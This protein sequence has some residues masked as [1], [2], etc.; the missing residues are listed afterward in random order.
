MYKINLMRIKQFDAN[1]IYVGSISF[2]E[3]NK[4][5]RLTARSATEKEQYQRESDKS[6]IKSISEYVYRSQTSSIIP[7]P[8]PLVLGTNTE[9]Y[10]SFNEDEI[11]MYLSK[12]NAKAVL[13][14][15]NNDIDTESDFFQLYLPETEKSIFIVDG[16][17]RFLGTKSFFES[18]EY[19]KSFN[20]LEFIVTFLLDYSIYE[21]ASVF[22]DI[23]FKQKPVNRS[24]YYDIFG[25]YA[26]DKNEI[27]FSYFL[28][29]ALNESTE[30]KNTIKMLGKGSGVVSLASMVEI[31]IK[32]LISP[33]GNLFNL[34][35]GY[36]HNNSEDYINLPEIFIDY[37]LY[38]K[39]KYI[40]YFPNI[41]LAD[42]ALKKFFFTKDFSSNDSKASIIRECEN[43]KSFSSMPIEEF[44]NVS[45]I[46]QA[47][48]SDKQN[49]MNRLYS[50]GYSTPYYNS[51]N[52]KK[53]YLFKAIGMYALL[54]IF[55]DIYPGVN[56]SRYTKESFYILLDEKFR[57]VNAEP[58]FFFEDE[59]LQG[60]GS[61]ALQTLCYKI[62]RSAVIDDDYD[63]HQKS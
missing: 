11:E 10:E 8:T 27:S 57:L 25:S 4:R 63:K 16:Q 56:S 62:L 44:F 41:M 53:S 19:D 39:K 38:I 61:A 13:V 26:E 15:N 58:S 60:S 23:N 2:S 59:R 42:E 48:C 51:Y 28:V 12:D 18:E 35:N 50:H 1:D 47:V 55:N 21:Q 30:Y 32:E 40:E 17:H 5:V 54:K 45:P 20:D 46:L 3:L 36:V 37:F 22:A 31:I 33:K 52:Y 14:Q 49:F 34:Y 9:M 29:R 43:D 7:F 6:R 24:I